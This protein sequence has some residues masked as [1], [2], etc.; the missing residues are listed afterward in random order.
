MIAA[1][2]AERD[3]LCRELLEVTRQRDEFRA[4]ARELRCIIQERWAA[5]ER[6]A[7]LH[8]E[9]AIARARGAERDPNAALN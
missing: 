9:R 3:A 6:V 7:E 4:C 5:E 8:R 2:I 1:L